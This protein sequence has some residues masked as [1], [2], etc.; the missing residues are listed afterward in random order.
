MSFISRSIP[1]ARRETEGLA[2]EPAADTRIFAALASA[3]PLDRAAAAAE[4]ADLLEEK[5]STQHHRRVGEMIA[6]A[7]P[8][9]RAGGLAA[10]GALLLIDG[11]DLGPRLS[12]YASPLRTALLRSVGDNEEALGAACEYYGELVRRGRDPDVLERE[13]RLALDALAALADDHGDTSADA[14]ARVGVP[15]IPAGISRGLL[16]GGGLGGGGNSAGSIERETERSENFPLEGRLLVAVLTLRQLSVH[17]PA[18]IYPHVAAALELWRP[19]TFHSA[20]VR[21]AATDA[22]YALHTPPHTRPCDDRPVLT[23]PAC[24]VWQVRDPRARGATRDALRTPVAQAAPARGSGGP[25]SGWCQPAVRRPRGTPRPL[26]PHPRRLVRVC[27]SRD[28][29]GDGQG[30][31]MQPCRYARSPTRSPTRSPEWESARRA[32]SDRPAYMPR[33]PGGVPSL[34]SLGS[35]GSMGVGGGSLHGGGAFTMGMGI[36]IS[37]SRGAVPADHSAFTI[38]WRAASRHLA[39]RRLPEL[40]KTSLGLVVDLVNIAPARFAARCLPDCVRLLS[41]MLRDQRCKLRAEAFVT[42]AAI[43]R[44][45]G[46]TYVRPHVAVLLASL[47]EALIRGTRSRLFCPAALASLTAIALS[48]GEEVAL[49]LQPLIRPVLSLPL[50][51]ALLEALHALTT[52][53]PSLA[54]SLRA[55]V[56][57]LLTHV[58]A[59]ASWRE[60]TATSAT[61]LLHHESAQPEYMHMYDDDGYAR[62]TPDHT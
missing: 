22:L 20:R 60:V 3:S 59:R 32:C 13:A 40:T 45:L 28:P 26:L 35:L 30:H 50:S 4:L 54:P 2:S 24:L 57:D 36:G 62:R 15:A 58:L 48:F 21:L 9:E 31:G 43:V 37:G 46:A 55:N 29:R 23:W 52:S 8:E 1:I 41:D 14:S 12:T 42:H 44:R 10:I 7:S 5:H 53:I 17:A 61:S 6:S 25:R 39:S 38:A 16:G 33:A 47:R 49:Q 51:S 19:L 27:P 56:L 34:G 11:E 18:A